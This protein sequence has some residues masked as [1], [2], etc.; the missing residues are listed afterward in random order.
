TFHTCAARLRPPPSAVPNALS[1]HHDGSAQPAR[2]HGVLLRLRFSIAAAAAKG[3][4]SGGA[5]IAVEAYGREHCDYWRL[6][7]TMKQVHGLVHG[8]ASPATADG[9]AAAGLCLVCSKEHRSMVQHALVSAL[10]FDADART[11]CLL[12]SGAGV[13]MRVGADARTTQKF[14]TEVD[15]GIS[16][17]APQPRPPSQL[18]VTQ[19]ASGTLAGFVRRRYCQV[20]KVRVG[21][22]EE[23]A[24]LLTGAIVTIYAKSNAGARGN[25]LSQVKQ[26]G[27]ATDRA[28]RIV[29]YDPR[30][31]RIAEACI[32]GEKDLRECVG[33]LQQPLRLTVVC[34]DNV[35]GGDDGS[36][37]CASHTDG[38]AEGGGGNDTLHGSTNGNGDT[39]V[40]AAGSASSNS[41]EGIDNAVGD[42][43]GG[44]TSSMAVDGTSSSCGNAGAGNDSGTFAVR[45]LRN[46][47]YSSVKQT[48]VH[49]GGGAD[50]R[51]NA[52]TLIVD[53]ATERVATDDVNIHRRG[54]KIYRGA[55]RIGGVL[56]QITAYELPPTEAEAEVPGG[57]PAL[58]CLAYDPG[59]QALLATFVAPPAV[60]EI[61]GGGTVPTSQGSDSSPSREAWLMCVCGAL[62]RYTK[63]APA[64]TTRRLD[65][66]TCWFNFCCNADSNGSLKLLA[67]WSGGPIG[68][69]INLTSPVKPGKPRADRTLARAR[70]PGAVIAAQ[71]SARVD[72]WDA[73][74]TAFT[75]GST[76]DGAGSVTSGS[77]TSSKAG[78]R[79][80]A[81]DHSHAITG[82]RSG[83]QVMFAPGEST[84]GF[85][86]PVLQRVIG[87]NGLRVLL[88]AYCADT[89]ATSTLHTSGTELIRQVGNKPHLLTGALLEDTV[90]QLVRR[91]LLKKSAIGTWQLLLDRSIEPWLFTSS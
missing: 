48:P 90:A 11:L 5:R 27:S 17:R 36:G 78:S 50:A 87:L 20:L 45:L 89:C 31:A 14:A 70:A 57:A 13:D 55:R 91:L 81:A 40:V 32:T 42:C 88:T 44:H 43:G 6:L 39:N 79:H 41:G 1:S 38:S 34:T 26:A 18:T 8:R 54:T 53:D 16:L 47:L 25:N 83:E 86:A 84:N 85:G 74:V 66:L 33:P 37:S 30:R 3:T 73:V 29:V 35:S 56:Y 61:A 80:I 77:N 24:S 28:L 67:P 71:F 68:T 21:P 52:A 12:C 62:R 2:M 58:K 10:R 15:E 59:S 23:A 4:A 63:T 82:G 7:V 60:E 76:V 22:W 75:E 64:C 72:G 69:L 9:A 65:G 49:V 19:P 46:R 51:A